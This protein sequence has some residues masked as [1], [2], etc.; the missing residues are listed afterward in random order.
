MVENSWKIHIL[1]F[2]SE[3]DP[4]KIHEMKNSCSSAPLEIMKW[5]IFEH[6]SFAKQSYFFLSMIKITNFKVI[7]SAFKGTNAYLNKKS[8]KSQT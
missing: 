7:L 5:R 2:F 6:F 3:I 1:K 8:A 4:K